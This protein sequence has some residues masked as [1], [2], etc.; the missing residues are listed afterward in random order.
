MYPEQFSRHPSASRH[1]RH[2]PPPIEPYHD[3]RS[4]S[5]FGPRPQGYGYPS[6]GSTGVSPGRAPPTGPGS[7]HSSERTSGFSP[8]GRLDI[9]IGMGTPAS[10]LQSS[11][12]LHEVRSDEMNEVRTPDPGHEDFRPTQRT[13]SMDSRNQ[14]RETINPLAPARDHVPEN[15]ERLPHID[16][17]GGFDPTDLGSIPRD[18]IPQDQRSEVTLEDGEHVVLS[19]SDLFD[20]PPSMEPDDVEPR[21]RGLA[22]S[23]SYQR[24]QRSTTPHSRQYSSSSH[25]YP[26]NHGSHHAVCEC[27]A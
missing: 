26:S 13:P 9:P 16:P 14:E 2:E 10:D 19:V 6:Q 22:P 17:T 8:H 3:V 12:R 27:S 4:S 21:E 24:S 18:A 1:R 20:R 7:R 11:H 23:L 25:S 15:P 5:R